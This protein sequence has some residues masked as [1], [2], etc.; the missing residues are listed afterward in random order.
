MPETTE[1]VQQQKKGK[2][3]YELSQED[4]D[5]LLS[6]LDPDT[7]IAGRKYLELKRKLEIIFGRLAD[8]EHLADVTLDRYCKKLKNIE[9]GVFSR[10]EQTQI[11]EKE[12]EE[13]K[14]AKREEIIGIVRNAAAYCAGIA[15]YVKKEIT[16]KPPEDPLPD[17]YSETWGAPEPVPDPFEDPL[18]KECYYK[19]LHALPADKRDM[20]ISYREGERSEKISNRKELAERLGLPQATLR[21]HIERWQGKLRECAEKCLKGKR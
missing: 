14:N 3:K 18:L 2:P 16:K 21:K 11:D 17:D 5:R 8:P 7:E 1:Q 6:V 9:S 12:S 10:E 4:F 13:A 15:R 19:C 20:L